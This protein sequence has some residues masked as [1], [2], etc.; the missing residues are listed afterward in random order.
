MKYCVVFAPE[1]NDQLLTLYRYI[2]CEASSDIAKRYTDAIVD[3]CDSLCV[4]PLRGVARDDVRVGL[5]ITHFKK[6]TIIAY[7]VE[8]TQVSILGIFYGGQ[9]YESLLQDEP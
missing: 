2:A 6:R 4:Y 1:A 9:D 8:G 3:F 5:R 7:D